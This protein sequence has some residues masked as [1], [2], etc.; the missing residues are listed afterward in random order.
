MVVLLDNVSVDTIGPQH[1]GSGGNFVAIVRGDNFG[2]GSVTLE[3][4]PNSADSFVIIDDGT[5]T[6][7]GQKTITS[8]PI[9]TKIRAQLS[10]SSGASNVRVELN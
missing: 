9:G 2:G 8:L 6:A 5:F 1:F 10:G 4:S 7:N 3:M